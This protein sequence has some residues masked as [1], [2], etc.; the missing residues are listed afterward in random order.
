MMTSVSQAGSCA[1]PCCAALP[2]AVL[3]LFHTLP[4]PWPCSCRRRRSGAAQWVQMNDSPGSWKLR[5][6]PW[7]LCL[8]LPFFF[9]FR[10]SCSRPAWPGPAVFY[11]PPSPFDLP[12]HR[13]S[14][15]QKCFLLGLTN[16]ICVYHKLA[17]TRNGTVGAKRSTGLIF[18]CSSTY[19]L[20]RFSYLWDCT[21]R[22]SRG[23]M[24]QPCIC[25]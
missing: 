5:G 24:L 12:T 14:R 21:G 8:C 4:W 17:D 25:S 6:C 3:C 11:E 10:W 7:L 18:T 19:G 2:C 13:F 16:G 23:F 20:L 15:P 1:S 9:V 22:P